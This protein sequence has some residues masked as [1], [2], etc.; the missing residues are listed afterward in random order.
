MTAPNVLLILSDDQRFDFLEY[1]PNTRNLVA[2]QGRD[3]VHARCNVAVCEPS[4]VSLLTGQYSIHN[5]YEDPV[6]SAAWRG[7]DPAWHNN[8]IGRWMQNA[9]YRT[10][11]IGKY[12]NFTPPVIPKPVGW[13]TW[14]QLNGE[15]QEGFGYQV[16]NGSQTLLSP[17]QLQIDYLRD[18]AKTFINNSETKPWFLLWT[19]TSPHLAFD[20][21]PRDLFAWSDVRWPL[22]IENDDNIAKKP[23]WISRAPIGAASLSSFRATARG[24][25]REITGLDRAIGDIIGSLTPEVLANTVVIFS[26]DNG[27][28]YGEHGLPHEGIFKNCAYDVGLRVPLIIRGP[29]FPVGV[30]TAPVTIAPDITATV[31]A[32]AGASPDVAFPPDGIDLRNM[33]ANPS[34]YENRQLL[35]YRGYRQAPSTMN[36]GPIADGI[37]TL[38]RKLYRCRSLQLN[39]EDQYEAYDLDSDPNEHLNWANEPGRLGDR[40]AL[41]AALDALLAPPEP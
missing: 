40:M 41:E 26:S 2:F 4:R 7:A 5:G 3:F 10:G 12:L 19:P 15:G 34:A 21:D 8:T 32:V 25:L 11:L 29:G 37:T 17:E 6:R 9:G 22:V 36:G 31:L 18:E 38:T 27:L 23:S 28:T 13:N 24:Q 39:T 33:I 20:P 16:C 1:M 14:R 30:S 35:H